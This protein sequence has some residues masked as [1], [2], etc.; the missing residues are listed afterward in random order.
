MPLGGRSLPRCTYSPSSPPA[1]GRPPPKQSPQTNA[2][3]SSAPGSSTSTCVRPQS[4]APALPPASAPTMTSLPLANGVRTRPEASLRSRGG[5]GETLRADAILFPQ[6][7]L[8]AP[9]GRVCAAGGAGALGLKSLS[10]SES[11]L[12]NMYP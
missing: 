9:G 4:P 6:P 2:A 7:R 12:T 5:V 3:A 1:A 10:P 8:P 11:F